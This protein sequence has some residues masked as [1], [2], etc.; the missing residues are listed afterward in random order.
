MGNNLQQLEDEDEEVL[1][2]LFIIE[3]GEFY[4]K[5]FF[6]TRQITGLSPKQVKV[7]LDSPPF[8]IASGYRRELFYLCDSFYKIGATTKMTMQ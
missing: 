2:N 5:V 7:L 3:I 1:C 8:L 6:L 4:P